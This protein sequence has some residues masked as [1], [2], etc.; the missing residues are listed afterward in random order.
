MNYS[1]LVVIKTVSISSTVP[2]DDHLSWRPILELESGRRLDHLVW[3]NLSKRPRPLSLPRCFQIGRRERLYAAG[4]SQ[5]LLNCLRLILFLSLLRDQS[6]NRFAQ[7]VESVCR[8]SPVLG[9]KSWLNHC[10]H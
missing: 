8:L 5:L 2:D 3:H 7:D 10:C 6:L 4:G 9:V 1:V